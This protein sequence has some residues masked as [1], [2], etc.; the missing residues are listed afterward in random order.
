MMYQEL[1]ELAKIEKGEDEPKDKFIHRLLIEIDKQTK[2]EFESLS[3]EAQ[4]YF[5]KAVKAHNEKKPLPSFPDEKKK[6]VG[7]KESYVKREDNAIIRMLVDH[8][9]KRKGS[10]SYDEFNLYKDG[11]TIKGFIKAGGSKASIRWDVNKGFIKLE[12]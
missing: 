1:K 12:G 5:N 10:R 6:E 7:P 9:P 8:N 2:E 3:K 11:M 4:E